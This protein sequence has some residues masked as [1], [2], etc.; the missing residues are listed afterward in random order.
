MYINYLLNYLLFRI[1]YVE[2]ILNNFIAY[3]FIIIIL[4]L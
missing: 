2:K 4:N 1:N 3:F